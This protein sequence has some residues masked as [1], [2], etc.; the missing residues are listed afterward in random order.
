MSTGRRA[1]PVSYGRQVG[2]EL[3]CC[4]VEKDL[5]VVGVEL[6]DEPTGAAV[7]VTVTVGTLR[8]VATVASYVT[9][10]VALPLTTA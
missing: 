10:S 3:G 8:L 1:P 4:G 9:V 7:A 6:H 2:S 5:R